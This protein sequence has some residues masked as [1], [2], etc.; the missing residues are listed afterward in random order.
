[1]VGLVIVVVAVVVGVS[2]GVVLVR[3]NSHCPPSIRAACAR[4][5]K[6]PWEL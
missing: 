3:A 1:V 4:L 2:V 5:L 6:T